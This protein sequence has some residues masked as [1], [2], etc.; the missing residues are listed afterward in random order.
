MSLTSAE[1][2]VQL[3]CTIDESDPD[4][5]AMREYSDDQ[6]FHIG[7]AIGTPETRWLPME[8]HLAWLLRDP[9]LKLTMEDRTHGAGPDGKLL[10]ALRPAGVGSGGF[11]RYTPAR[12]P[13]LLAA[14]TSWCA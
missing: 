6:A 11:V 1:V 8:A 12:I 2:D 5:R 13:E 14:P 3:A 9:L 7:Y 10:I 4:E